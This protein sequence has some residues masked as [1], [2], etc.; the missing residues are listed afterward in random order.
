MDSQVGRVGKD[1]MGCASLHGFI[2]PIKLKKRE[3]PAQPMPY[4][5]PV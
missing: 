3:N 4:R 2:E 1:L 5:M